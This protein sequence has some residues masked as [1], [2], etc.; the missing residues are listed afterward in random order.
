[1]CRLLLLQFDYADIERGLSYDCQQ[2]ARKADFVDGMRTADHQDDVN[3]QLVDDEVHEF[4]DVPARAGRRR[5]FRAVHVDHT[6][7]NSVS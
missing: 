3:L 6:S 1:M 2:P 7:V 4:P 5:A